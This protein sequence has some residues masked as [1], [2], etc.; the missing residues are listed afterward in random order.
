MRKYGNSEAITSLFSGPWRR[1]KEVGNLSWFVFFKRELSWMRPHV[2]IGGRRNTAMM[3]KAAS[4]PIVVE[5]KNIN[6]LYVI[7]FT[8]VG[9]KRGIRKLLWQDHV[10]WN[11]SMNI[12]VA[13]WG[14]STCFNAF[15][16]HRRCLKEF[17]MCWVYIC[18]TTVEY[19][20]CEYIEF[21][22]SHLNHFPDFLWQYIKNGGR[23]PRMP[24]SNGY[25][26]L[27]KMGHQKNLNT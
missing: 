11:H 20:I 19:Q 16:C 23:F 5:V 14:G 4:V 27:F 15:G 25:C 18:A 3:W 22:Q 9:H 13:F 1:I 10:V 21:L 7:I 26:W 24:S 2:F 8:Y 17:D 12:G 6:P